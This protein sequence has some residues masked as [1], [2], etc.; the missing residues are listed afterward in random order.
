MNISLSPR[1]EQ[2][3]RQ[4]V[5]SGFYDSFDQVIAEALF[6]LEERDQARSMR[7]ERLLEEIATGVNQADNRQLMDGIEVFRS[8]HRKP[9]S[10]SDD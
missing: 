3:V 2:L 8:L 6:L 4:K 9:S 7:R 5:A 1:Q 10:S